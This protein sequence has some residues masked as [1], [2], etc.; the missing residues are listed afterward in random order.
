MI[1]LFFKEA[2]IWNFNSK[3]V[4]DR[5]FHPRSAI[6][7]VDTSK[8]RFHKTNPIYFT[9]GQR[10]M[11]DDLNEGPFKTLLIKMDEINKKYETL[12]TPY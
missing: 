10:I 5:L 7:V 3:A 12:E 2:Q 8:T 4:L 1:S 9:V 6:L 11:E